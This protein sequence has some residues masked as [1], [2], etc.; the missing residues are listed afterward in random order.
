MMHGQKNIKYGG[1]KKD[2]AKHDVVSASVT[3]PSLQ[4]ENST[5]QKLCIALYQTASST[6]VIASFGIH[7]P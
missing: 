2:Y 7:V 6:Y 5:G 4:F 3:P 1:G